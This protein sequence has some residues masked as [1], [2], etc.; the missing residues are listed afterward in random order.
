MPDLYISVL[1]R[2]FQLYTD[3]SAT[4][5]GACLAQNDEN[6]MEHPIALYSKKL[7]IFQMNW[8]TIKREANAIL[9]A[10]KK[11]DCC[12]YVSQIQVVS[13]QNPLTFLKNG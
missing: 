6:G 13:D 10:L 4:I 5:V 11:F 2:P 7:T 12:I 3:A 9:S 1:N 8:S